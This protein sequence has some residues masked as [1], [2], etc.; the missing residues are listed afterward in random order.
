M[1]NIHCCD[2]PCK[3]MQQIYLS[4]PSLW[5]YQYHRWNLH[6]HLHHLNI[7]MREFHL[8][9]LLLG[10]TLN[11]LVFCLKIIFDTF[12]GITPYPQYEWCHHWQLYS[13]KLNGM[14]TAL[15]WENIKSYLYWQQNDTDNWYLLLWKRRN[16]WHGWWLYGNTRTQGI[17]SHDAGL[18]FLE[19]S[20]F[21]PMVM[22]H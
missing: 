18:I 8:H 21:P 15:Y 9:I 5:C 11:M 7:W 22:K 6:D 4:I 19:H 16:H 20:S 13:S 2:I 1:I 3:D 10:I 12:Q 17:S 14:C